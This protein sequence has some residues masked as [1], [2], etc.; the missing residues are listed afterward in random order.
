MVRVYSSFWLSPYLH[1]YFPIKGE[2][3][4]VVVH[5]IIFT[6]YTNRSRDKVN[7]LIMPRVLPSWLN[8]KCDEIIVKSPPSLFA[9]AFASC[10]SYTSPEG[11][12]QLEIFEHCFYLHPNVQ[13]GII[14]KG[15]CVVDTYGCF[16]KFINNCPSRD[17]YSHHSE[18][19]RNRNFYAKSSRHLR[20][21][22]QHVYP[23][24]TESIILKKDFKWIPVK[25]INPHKRPAH[26]TNHSSAKRRLFE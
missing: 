14:I 25:S 1:I 3:G 6:C 26:A 22:V 12:S 21:T 2:V 9:I 16:D 5:S 10:A 17:V 13:V 18:F 11:E 7:K 4:A 20:K 19:T 8:L 15:E 23:I 24:N